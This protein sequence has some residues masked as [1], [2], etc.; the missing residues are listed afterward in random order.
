MSEKKRVIV[1]GDLAAEG[2]DHLLGEGLDVEAGAG[3][4]DAEL[5]RRVPG[6]HGIVAGPGTP[7]T[8]AVLAASG[9]LKVVGSAGV[10]VGEIDVAEATRRGIVV[11]H[12]PDSALNSE[13]EHALALVLACAR[14]LTGADADLRSGRASSRRPGDGIEVRGKTLGLAVTSGALHGSTGSP[15]DRPSSREAAR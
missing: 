9:E 13:A 3:W 11:V 8:A 10:D 2:V 14:D 15:G 12:A 4:D 6:C 7:V 5:L 1:L